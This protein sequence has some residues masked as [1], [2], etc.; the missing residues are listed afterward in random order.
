MTGRVRLKADGGVATV[1]FDRPASYNAM[2][3]AMYTELGTAISSIRSDQS[4]RA[5]VFRGAGKAFVAG[6]EISEFTAFAS[7][8]D[9]IA[10]EERIEAVV[11]AIEDLPMPTL[12]VVEG[13]AM[14]GGIIIAAA[15]DFRLITP[16]ARFGAPIART[17]GNCLSAR[18]TGRLV[19]A[20][21][22]S[23]TRRILMLAEIVDA[24]SAAACGFAL[25]VVASE[26]LEE[27]LASILGSVMRHAPITMQI[28]KE[29]L[30]RRPAFDHTS[31]AEL[32]RLAYGSNDFRE[33]VA[34]F[35]EKRQPK[36]SGI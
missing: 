22:A 27:N 32:V 19:A 11:S 28:A 13:A 12:S 29:I 5:V 2:T 10:Y 23:V 6:T 14:G 21:G 31:D 18:N 25:P 17:V 35:L 26:E 7:A 4:I 20:F 9:G 30:R 36:W 16:A 34:S 24:R 33:G 1:T 8:E 3:F 15:C